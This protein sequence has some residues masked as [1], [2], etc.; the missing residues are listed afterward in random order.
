M[1]VFGE[2]V[3]IFGS[4]LVSSLFWRRLCHEIRGE[5]V[6]SCINVCRALPQQVL[7]RNFRQ[8][9]R[10][11]KMKETGQ[12]MMYTSKRLGY[13]SENQQS[14][15]DTWQEQY[16]YFS[17]THNLQTGC[18][19]NRASYSMGFACALPGNKWMGR[20]AG[21]LRECCVKNEWSY[22]FTSLHTF[23]TYRGVT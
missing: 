14:W 2:A 10:E 3:D 19:T 11:F 4:F 22:S 17:P 20:E 12:V 7:L 16:M 9:S 21:W 8:L 18:G 13:G 15:L 23:M 5:P 6:I 1:S